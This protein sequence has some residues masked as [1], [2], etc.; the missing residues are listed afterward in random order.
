[1]NKKVIGV[2]DSGVGGIVVLNEL[3]KALP[4][5]EFLYVAD[6]QNSPYGE[7]TKEEVREIVSKNCNYLYEKNSKM[8]VIACNTATANSDHIKLDIPII[9]VIETTAKQVYELPKNS[10]VLLVATNVTVNSKS[11]QNYLKD[12]NVFSIGVPEFVKIVEENL[13][14][15]QEAKTLVF[16]KLSKFQKEDIKA[17]I[18][19][20][21]HFELLKD[22]VQE[23][24]PKAKVYSSSKVM[25]DEVKNT[26]IR[27]RMLETN[28]FGKIIIESNKKN[29]N[30][31]D[32]ISW[33]EREYIFKT[34]K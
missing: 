24:F 27:K 21:T 29:S 31:T 17:V 32:K 26:L 9:G 2:F 11:Y 12:Y 25:A 19:G 10:N 5:E 13:Y 16:D 8:I 15:T 28:N 23:I 18:L 34:K 14:S 22:F 6:E 30:I 20:C 4:N 33:F 1:M 3:V 7:K